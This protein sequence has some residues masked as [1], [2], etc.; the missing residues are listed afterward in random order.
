[1][2]SSD[3]VAGRP[4]GAGV[5][6]EPIK[7]R[8]YDKITGALVWEFLPPTRPMASPMTYTYLGVQYLVVATGSGASAELIAFTVQ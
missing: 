7:L 4:L 3:L 8:A 1:V 2:C 6:P 5:A